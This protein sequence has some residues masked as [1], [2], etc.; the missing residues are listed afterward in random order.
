MLDDKRAADAEAAHR[1]ERHLHGAADEVDLLARHVVVLGDAA[2]RLAESGERDRLVDENAIL[3]ARLP[4]DHL[5]QRTQVAVVEVEA[6][7]D[8]EA[9]RHLG[10]LGILCVRL[11]LLLEQALQVVEIVVL[12]VADV[13]ARR[14]DALLHGEVHALVGEYDVAALRV[15]R[16][17]AGDCR[18]AVR[19]DDALLHVEELRQTLLQVQ[20]HI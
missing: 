9:S 8:E 11:L 12:E 13:A 2:A 20:V 5:G 16:Y 17:G 3:V 6:L 1:A 7:D 14:Y 18:E 15:R 4:L 19:V 10:L